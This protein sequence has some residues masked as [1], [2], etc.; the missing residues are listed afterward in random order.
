MS[1]IGNDDNLLIIF[2]CSFTMQ[3]LNFI[4]SLKTLIFPT[5]NVLKKPGREVQKTAFPKWHPENYIIACPQ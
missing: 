1:D 4:A 2:F 3:L 5:A